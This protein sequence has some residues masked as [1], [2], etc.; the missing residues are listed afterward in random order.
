MRTRTH[1]H[2]HT[3]THTCAHTHTGPIPPPECCSR[4]RIHL[5]RGA[6]PARGQHSPL[7]GHLALH[8][9]FLGCKRAAFLAV[10]KRRASTPIKSCKLKA[11]SL[12]LNIRTQLVS[13]VPKHLQP[14]GDIWKAPCS[15]KG[16]NWQYP[17][18]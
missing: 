6:R 15:R 4:P 5:R 2:T 12:D 7:L 3:H 8:R 11:A 14:T 17:L 16:C 9:K 13:E 10:R 18:L 1:T